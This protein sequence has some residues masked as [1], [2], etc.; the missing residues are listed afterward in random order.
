M[1]TFIEQWLNDICGNIILHGVR[2]VGEGNSILNRNETFLFSNKKWLL[3]VLLYDGQALSSIL[4][5]ID[6]YYK[7]ILFL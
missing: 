2:E 6:V 7:H 1:G 4:D 5:V 3:T